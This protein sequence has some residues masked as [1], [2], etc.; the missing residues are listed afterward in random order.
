MKL[1]RPVARNAGVTIEVA[2]RSGP[3]LVRA[4][5]GAIQQVLLNLLVNAVEASPRAG[6]VL[7]T[8]G[9]GEHGI[10]VEVR[11]QGPGIA[12][13]NL[14]RIFEP[15][16]TTKPRTTGLGLFL[17]REFTRQWGGDLL[18]ANQPGGGAVFRVTSPPAEA[19]S[20]P[21]G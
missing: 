17:A 7:V 21:E 16:F 3:F 9:P 19:G 12:P 11:D 8:V 1:A 5:E 20:V 2:A 4:G 15:F 6:R 13:E 18:A 14:L 10:A